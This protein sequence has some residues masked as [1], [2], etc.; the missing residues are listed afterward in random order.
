MSNIN[1]TSPLQNV[2]SV[3]NAETKKSKGDKSQLVKD[4]ELSKEQLS[5][6]SQLKNEIKKSLLEGN[7][8]KEKDLSKVRKMIIKKIIDWQLGDLKPPNLERDKLVES[9]AQKLESNNDAKTIIDNFIED[10]EK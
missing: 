1:R 6:K 3:L 10:M 7:I 9:V 5:R 4:S 8:R 2:I